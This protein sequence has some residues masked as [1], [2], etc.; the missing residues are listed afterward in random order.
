MRDKDVMFSAPWACTQSVAPFPWEVTHGG[1]AFLNSENWKG[2]GGVGDTQYTGAGM[3]LTKQGKTVT[4]Q[5][6]QTGKKK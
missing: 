2:W 3:P 4:W 6:F 1:D 5:T